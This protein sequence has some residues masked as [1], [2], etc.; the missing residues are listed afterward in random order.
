[1]DKKHYRHYDFSLL[2][3]Q[4]KK[5]ECGLEIAEKEYIVPSANCL[6]SFILRLSSNRY[7][8]FH[9]FDKV[10]WKYLWKNGLIASDKNGSHCFAVLRHVSN[11]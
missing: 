1:M 9:F 2:E 5:A 7:W 8:D 10:L 6:Y 3:E 11:S 4:L